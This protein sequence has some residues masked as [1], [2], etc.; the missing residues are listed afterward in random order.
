MGHEEE[1]PTGMELAT[2]HA[3][4]TRPNY[5]RC[6]AAV[7]WF[8][9]SMH[10][11]RAVVRGAHTTPR[12]TLHLLKPRQM[13]SLAMRTIV[14]PSPDEV[15]ED[16]E[17]E[18]EQRRLAERAKRKTKHKARGDALEKRVVNISSDSDAANLK[19]ASPVVQRQ[20]DEATHRTVIE[21]SGTEQQYLKY[22][23]LY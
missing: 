20:R 14:P 10:T 12:H 17:P 8:C 13:L 5:S 9:F 19:A 2:R 7:A 3:G 15:V 22:G 23:L 11:L 6:H 18:R 21:I 16:S 4:V 1:T